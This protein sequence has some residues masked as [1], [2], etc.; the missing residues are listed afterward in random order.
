MPTA[1][2]PREGIGHGRDQR[3]IAQAYQRGRFNG[4]EQSAGFVTG[5]VGRLAFSY[6]MPGAT[7]RV[8]RIHIDDVAGHEPVEQHAQ[9]GQI[10]FDRRRC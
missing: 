7:H 9:R 6:D 2:D 1:A 4:I 5:E 10:L 8:G 3:A